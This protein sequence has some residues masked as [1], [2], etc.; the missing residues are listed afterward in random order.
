MTENRAHRWWWIVTGCACMLVAAKEV[1]NEAARQASAAR[2]RSARILELPQQAQVVSALNE[3]GSP[4]RIAV[5]FSLPDTRSC[6]EWLRYLTTNTRVM[7]VSQYEYRTADS[8]LRVSYDPVA[9]IYYW[10]EEANP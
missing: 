5:R 3:F 1:L 2:I 8:S 7:K 9:R 6:D 4:R 10:E